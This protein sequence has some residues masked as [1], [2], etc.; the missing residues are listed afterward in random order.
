MNTTRTKKELLSRMNACLRSELSE[1]R[2]YHH[3]YLSAAYGPTQHTEKA[4]YFKDER[5]KHRRAALLLADILRERPNSPDIL[6]KIEDIR[7][8]E[9][10]KTLLEDVE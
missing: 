8:E 1:A 3:V 9:T 7:R 4:I 10:L 6:S 5:D 2:C